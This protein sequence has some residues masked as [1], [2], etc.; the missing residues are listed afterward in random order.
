MT[1]EQQ[2]QFRAK[3]QSERKDAKPLRTLRL[4]CAF[5]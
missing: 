2:Q 5:A 1:E 3:A 4:L